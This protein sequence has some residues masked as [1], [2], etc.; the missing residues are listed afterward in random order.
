MFLAEQTLPF[1]N[2]GSDLFYLFL[3]EIN[4]SIQQRHIQLIKSDST[5]VT[6]KKKVILNVLFIKKNNYYSFHEKI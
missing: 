2:M 5:H 6:Q 4:T 3:E 1:K